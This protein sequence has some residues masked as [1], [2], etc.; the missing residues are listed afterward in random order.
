MTFDEDEE[1]KSVPEKNSLFVCKFCKSEFRD[2]KDFRAHRDGCSASKIIHQCSCGFRHHRSRQVYRHA[3]KK[4]HKGVTKVTVANRK[5]HVR[6]R[7]QN[8]RKKMAEEWSAQIH[9]FP[10]FV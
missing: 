7:E 9:E 2:P 8:E 10:D 5:F 3:V 6:I 1:D 4:N